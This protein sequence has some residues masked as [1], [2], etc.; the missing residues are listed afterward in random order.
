MPQAHH[1]NATITCGA[2]VFQIHAPGNNAIPHPP[3]K[4]RRIRIV[5][6]PLGSKDFPGT[7][8]LRIMTDSQEQLPP[9]N[10]GG[11]YD[12]GNMWSLLCS[13]RHRKRIAQKVNRIDLE[14]NRQNDLSH[15][16]FKQARSILLRFPW[17]VPAPAQKK[18]KSI[19][20]LRCSSMTLNRI[21]ANYSESQPHEN[22]HH[23]THNTG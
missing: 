21:L 20:Y 18:R 1:R 13:G 2:A 11:F 8:E 15:G 3:G 17:I 5:L 9:V 22:T 23:T 16:N 4:P 6:A 19:S 10:F 12:Q 14:I 7:V